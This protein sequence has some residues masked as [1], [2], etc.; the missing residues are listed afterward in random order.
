MSRL[1]V[2]EVTKEVMRVIRENP[3]G[4]QKMKLVMEQRPEWL[5]VLRK[6]TEGDYAGETNRKESL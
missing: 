3:E 2:E 5:K 1:T 4:V 6:M